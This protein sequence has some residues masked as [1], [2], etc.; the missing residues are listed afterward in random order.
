MPSKSKNQEK[1]MRIAAHTTGGYGGVS[2]SVGREF[3][4]ADKK[5][6]ATKDKIK[7]RY[8]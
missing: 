5:K 6:E 2:Q 8:K 1:L 4:M 3:E 7:K